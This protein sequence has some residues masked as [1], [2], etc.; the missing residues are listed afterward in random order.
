MSN[1]RIVML[2]LSGGP[3]L[4]KDGAEPALA[5]VVNDAIYLVDCGFETAKQM[6]IADLGFANLRG[7]FI[8]HNHLDHTSGILGVLVHGW[9]N[10]GS[11]LPRQLH[12]WGPTPTARLKHIGET[13]HEHDVANYVKGGGFGPFPEVVPHDVVQTGDVI[14]PVMEDENVVVTATKVFHGAELKD[15][16]AYRFYIKATGK[17]VVFSGDTAAPDANLIELSQNCDFLVHEVQDNEMV[18]RV[19]SRI[20]LERQADLRNHLFSSHSSVDDLP[21][22]AMN[23]KA[24]HLVF[25]HYTPIPQPAS[26]YLDKAE[27]AANAIGYRGKII[28]P[29]ELD[30]I[31]IS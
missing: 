15:S 31:E 29:V 28:A 13:A 16:F 7:I 2:G 9:T 12:I 14:I 26:V 6:V 5:L 24:K 4:A 18:E 3:K 30:V 11:E 22:V 19:V 10:L 27:R 20:P 21:G 17:S 23:S 1:D 8:T 25:C